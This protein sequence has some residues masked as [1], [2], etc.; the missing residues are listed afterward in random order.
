MVGQNS[1]ARR[2]QST[3]PRGA[4]PASCTAEPGRCFNPRAREGRDPGGRPGAW[5][6]CSFNPR[7]REGRDADCRR[8]R[9]CRYASFN[10]RAREGRDHLS[11]TGDAAFD[12]AFQSTRPRG[13]R[14]IRRRTSMRVEF[15]F[16][17][18]RPRGA[19]HAAAE[20][21]PAAGRFNPRAREGRDKLSPDVLALAADGFNPRAREGRDADADRLDPATV[22]FQSTR[23]RGARQCCNR[24]GN[25][26]QRCFNPRAR[27]GR[28]GGS[29]VAYSSVLS[30]SIHAPAR[31]ATRPSRFGG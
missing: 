29:S 27:E 12:A 21:V 30:V 5:C 7:A 20:G 10:P 15:M 16:Q 23:P 4:R 22:R 24:G 26:S 31:G 11:V 17:S 3:R 9:T 25:S 28:D 19:R 8:G 18:T 13:A 1:M 2:F 14:L 6:S